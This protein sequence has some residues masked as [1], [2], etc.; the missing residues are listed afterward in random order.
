MRDPFDLDEPVYDWCL[1]L[2]AEA[3]RHLGVRSVLHHVPE[4]VAQ[5]DIFVFNRLARGPSFLPQYFVFDACGA[6]CR[7]VVAGAAFRGDARRARLLREL[8]AV[9][10]DQ[11]GLA[12]L[13][14]LDLLKG[15]RIAFS[16]GE[17]AGPDAVD[18]A[19][20]LAVFLA[21]VRRRMAGGDTAGLEHWV[22]TLGL[23]SLQRL[24]ERAARPVTVV[25]AHITCHPRHVAHDVPGHLAARLAGR[26]STLDTGAVTDDAALFLGATGLDVR[27]GE[28][29]RV[30]TAWRWAEHRAAAVLARELPAPGAAFAPEYRTRSAL[31]RW[32][33]R[34]LDAAGR[35][36][37]ERIADEIRRGATVDASQLAARLL[38]LARERGSHL[39]ERARLARL[40]YLAA[41][42]L[43]AQAGV[44]LHQDL[45]DP[46]RY[47]PLADGESSALDALLEAAAAGGDLALDGTW[48]RLAG[49]QDAPVLADV[50][51]AIAPLPD[52]EQAV[53][54][55]WDAHDALTPQAQG[56]L[57]FD[58]LRAE[59]AWDRRQFSRPA[60]RAIN[61]R[62]SATA[63]ASPFL[64][65]PARPRAVGV[66]LA[67]GF[68][69]SPAEMRPL[70][71]RLRQADFRVL[72]VR[73]KG[74][75][76]S[77]WDLR[78]RCWQDWLA[79]VA[80]GYATLGAWC[81]RICV[82]GFSTG[83]ALA[84]AHAATRP[85]G[86]RGV[87]ACS[88]PI[89]FRNSQM[90]YVPLVHGANRL[91]A[92]AS[93][94]EGPMPFR[95]NDP[96]HPDINYR[97]MPLRGLHELTRMVGHVR[98]CLPD[99]RCPALILQAT[100]DH[101]VDPRSA[102]HVYEHIGSHDKTLHW[103]PS[104]RHG[105]VHGDIGDTH[106]RIVEFAQRL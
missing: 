62:E 40:V 96:E 34:R 84:L 38:L 47:R 102:Q 101:V 17:A 55:A 12:T 91:V 45:R 75:G 20:G 86:L 53:R 28:P 27:L 77:P 41:K 15:R 68:L 69:S 92:W 89:H 95:R 8:G 19:Q 76:T 4:Q 82:V 30:E 57:A 58:D 35:G 73:L 42:K 7:S 37:R 65:H 3:G 103:I 88:T 81:D 79:S 43:Q 1:R 16:A 104:R 25:P 32:A 26:H 56:A 66:L 21:A 72:G 44:H 22:D 14:A 67:H 80:Q 97:H 33:A 52:V 29:L 93:S 49:R 98:D 51:A 9:P 78:E 105:I 23:P 94:G 59:H 71:E 64:L 5:A 46:Q 87:V 10:D 85:A 74:H 13:L 39:M 48:I 70:A 106:A 63:D 36:L 24:R 18:L 31:R 99:V 61:A 83:A 100:E 2:H 60:H 6:R 54:A 11:P 90:R 50:A